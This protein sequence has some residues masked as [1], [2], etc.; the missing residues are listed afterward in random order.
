LSFFSNCGRLPREDSHDVDDAA[1]A[2][3]ASTF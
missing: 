3:V 2:R 1:I